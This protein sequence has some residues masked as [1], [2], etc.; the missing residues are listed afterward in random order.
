MKHKIE[1]LRQVGQRLDKTVA[2]LHPEFSRSALEKLIVHGQITVNNKAV[3]TK[4]KLKLDDEVSV[5]TTQLDREHDHID[6]PIIY[7]DENVVAL[8]KPAGILTHSKGQFNKEGTVATWLQTHREEL[9][10]KD[11][12]GFWQNERSGIVHRL[13]R[14]TSGIIICAKNKATHE[15]IQ[16]QFS[17]R[18]VKK[19]YLAVV[20]GELSKTEGTIDIPIE[21]NPKK[22]ATFRTGVNGK[23]AQTHFTVE[24]V[25]KMNG[26]T[27]SIVELK[28]RTGRTHQ[29]RVHLNYLKK[30]IVGD[31]F[32]GGEKGPRL[33]LHALELELTLP[34]GVRRRLYIDMPKL[35]SEYAQ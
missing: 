22:P 35:F 6:L 34:G 17:N 3:K 7:E 27:Y 25:G 4:Y 19:T 31:E 23:E 14:A 28:P 1:D 12:E 9:R 32:Y 10:L 20:A 8:N 5:I 18:T 26:K 2:Q 30:P 11:E 13:D 33:L 15:F 16:K 29:L 24:K 21:R